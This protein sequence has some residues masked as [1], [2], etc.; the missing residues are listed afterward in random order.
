VN[1]TAHTDSQSELA[2]EVAVNGAHAPLTATV[3]G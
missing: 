2:K 1:I 3:K